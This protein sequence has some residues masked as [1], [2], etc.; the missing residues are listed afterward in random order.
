MLSPDAIFLD[1]DIGDGN[2]ENLLDIIQG[3]LQ[4]R[5]LLPQGSP[6]LPATTQCQEYANLDL[7]LLS[8]DMAQ[9]VVQIFNV[10]VDWDSGVLAFVRLARSVELHLSPCDAGTRFLVLLFTPFDDETSHRETAK[11]LAAILQVC[12]LS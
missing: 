11:A 8:P 5:G 3:R 7:D 9:D 1:L 2:L 10:S 12:P 4:E 6:S